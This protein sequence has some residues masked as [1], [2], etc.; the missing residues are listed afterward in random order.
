MIDASHKLTITQMSKPVEEIHMV[1]ELNGKKSQAYYQL[2][3]IA[4]ESVATT[5]VLAAVVNISEDFKE[6]SILRMGPE[7]G[8]RRLYHLRSHASIL[9]V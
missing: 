9:N 8:Q 6:M 3:R 2:G 5:V 1:H 4:F 7:K